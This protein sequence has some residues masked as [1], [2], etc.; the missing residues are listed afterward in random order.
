MDYIRK[1]HNGVQ[2]Y[3]HRWVW[4]QAHGAIPKGMSIHHINSNKTDNRLENLKLVTH[5]ENHRQSD[6]WG[7]GWS[8]A[9]GQTKPYRAMRLT[10]YLGHFGTPCG[11][12]MANRM[13]YING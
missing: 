9:E 4:T 13:Y 5:K 7:R 12:Y 8:Y 10:K 11:A 2:W 3:E 6:K 1:Y